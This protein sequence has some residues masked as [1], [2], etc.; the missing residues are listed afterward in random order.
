MGLE[1]DEWV[2]W[3]STKSSADGSNSSGTPYRN[4][5]DDKDDKSDEWQ[6]SFAARKWIAKI[7]SLSRFA[8]EAPFRLLEVSFSP[9][10]RCARRIPITAGFLLIAALA[11][12]IRRL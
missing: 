8:G 10:G 3:A 2:T 12:K 6:T 11:R 1:V 5:P 7:V 4:G 9:A